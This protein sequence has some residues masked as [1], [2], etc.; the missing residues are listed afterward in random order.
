MPFM[1]EYRG[2]TVSG[3]SRLPTDGFPGYTQ[4]EHAALESGHLHGS[5]DIAENG[6]AKASGQLLFRNR[7]EALSAL[8]KNTWSPPHPDDTMPL[9]DRHRRAYVLVL[10]EAMKNKDGTLDKKGSRAA[11]G[12]WLRNDDVFYWTESDMEK[13]CWDI[14]V[15]FV[16]CYAWS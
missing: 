7:Q 4:L 2:A 5:P 14:V 3:S 16:N 9:S 8:Q 15:R 10:L 13:A 6:L 1:Q 12:R 11:Q